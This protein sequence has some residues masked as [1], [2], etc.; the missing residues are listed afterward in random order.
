MVGNA[1]APQSKAS[2]PPIDFDDLD[3]PF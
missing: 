3:I 1:P 2:E